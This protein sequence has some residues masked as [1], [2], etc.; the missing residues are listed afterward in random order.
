MLGREN[1]E[2]SRARNLR[3]PVVQRKGSDLAR[4]DLTYTK[5]RMSSS[6]SSAYRKECLACLE[7]LPSSSF[8]K[9]PI[10]P[11]CEHP[12][13]QICQPCLKRSLQAQLDDGADR[14]FSCPL[15]RQPMSERD[16]KRWAK[17]EV[18]RRY[19]SIRTRKSLA[20][21]PNFIWCSNPNCK[22]GQVHIS[23]AQSPIM[24]CIYCRSRTCFTH[25]RPWHE[26]MTCYDF[27]HPEVVIEQERRQRN[28]EAATRRKIQMQ[29]EEDEA[30]AQELGAKDLR[31]SKADEKAR[32]KAVA[33]E[34]AERRAQKA[35]EE[36]R[37][38]EDE[39]RR[40]ED[41]QKNRL[42]R[43]EEE[44][45]GEAE[46]R[47]TSK[48]CPGSGCAYRIYRDGGCRH[49][50]CTRCGH[51]WCWECLKTWERGHLSACRYIA[52]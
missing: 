38:K 6:S 29:L 28:E 5:T 52:I 43:L 44:R 35:K 13:G 36:R 37:R 16:V 2:I 46:V 33:R 4:P 9:H 27:D 30:I 32:K 12:L 22:G 18:V 17:P 3:T 1:G 25:Q 34:Q 41:R 31:R 20:A 10:S 11:G 51:E 49:I 21:D 8:P 42:R 45:L 15:C 47:G 19:N 40:D 14:R 23:G 24:T 26:G 39:K 50:T 7:E 48:E